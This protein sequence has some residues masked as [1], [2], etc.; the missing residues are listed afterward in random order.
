MNKNLNEWEWVMPYPFNTQSYSVTQTSL[1]V[2]LL[3]LVRLQSNIKIFSIY[4]FYRAMAIWSFSASTSFR[5][6][7]KVRLFIHII[8]NAT[9][10]LVV[11]ISRS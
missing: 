11:V 6:Y 5:L 7:N 9:C 10:V 4:A 2:L 3:R 8:W 1:D